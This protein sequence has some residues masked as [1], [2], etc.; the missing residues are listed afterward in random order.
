VSFDASES[1]G[2]RPAR[3]A[4]QIFEEVGTFGGRLPVD[5]FDLVRLGR[6]RVRLGLEGRYT[7]GVLDVSPWPSETRN[8]AFAFTTVVEVR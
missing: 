4:A 5:S 8:A 3:G 6:G 2:A 7:R 1:N